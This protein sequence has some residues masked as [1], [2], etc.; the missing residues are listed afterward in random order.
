[1]EF[2]LKQ[3][4]LVVFTNELLDQNQQVCGYQKSIEFPCGCK[5]IGK[6]KSIS[7]AGAQLRLKLQAA[8]YELETKGPALMLPNNHA[9]GQ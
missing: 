4:K 6:G 7:E 9:Q 5:Y 1:M 2:N 3:P 8:G